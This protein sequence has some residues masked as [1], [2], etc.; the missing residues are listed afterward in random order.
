[1]NGFVGH[2]RAFS[3]ACS[4][5]HRSPISLLRAPKGGLE[6]DVAQ[7]P[8][9]DVLSD[10]HFPETRHAPSPSQA[11]ATEETR[12]PTSSSSF[13]SR[14]SAAGG[15]WLS[16]ITNY[17]GFPAITVHRILGRDDLLV[18]EAAFD[19]SKDGSAPYRVCDVQECP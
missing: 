4:R 17:P 18:T 13:S 6:H 19:Y 14:V 5:P 11:R 1:M 12:T 10:K 2:W 9:G 3:K 16:F 8:E 15:N 7:R